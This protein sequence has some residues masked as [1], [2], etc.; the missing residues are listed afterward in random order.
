MFLA[1]KLPNVESLVNLLRIHAY[2]SEGRFATE[3][4]LQPGDF[5]PQRMST[6]D[7]SFLVELLS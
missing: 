5:L 2:Q 3:K 4:I 7:G 1:F 6:S